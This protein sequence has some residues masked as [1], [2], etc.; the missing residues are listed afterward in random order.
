MKS[1]QVFGAA[2][3]GSVGLLGAFALTG[4]STGHGGGAACVI[5]DGGKLE[6]AVAETAS[7]TDTAGPGTDTGDA[8]VPPADTF[9]PPTDTFVPPPDTVVPPEDTFV[10]PED[11]FVPPPD[12]T[13]ADTGSAC[14]DCITGSCGPETAA[15]KADS[16]CQAQITCLQ[17]CSDSTCESDCISAHPSTS[18]DNFF[19]CANT[20][21]A[22]A[23]GG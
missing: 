20:N 12:T 21:C 13:P 5:L 8:A 6:C 7:T 16:A 18:A 22:T 11:T 1:I 19:N 23:C 4:C 15:C 2:L 9:V 3:V 17:G 10:P 14:N